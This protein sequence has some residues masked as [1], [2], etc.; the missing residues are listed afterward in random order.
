MTLMHPNP[1][2]H[3][4]SVGLQ[5]TGLVGSVVGF[6][7]VPLFLGFLV[8]WLIAGALAVVLD[9]YAIRTE[10]DTKAMLAALGKLAVLVAALFML[11]SPGSIPAMVPNSIPPDTGPVVM[12]LSILPSEL[13]AMLRRA[14]APM[15]GAAAGM[16]REPGIPPELRA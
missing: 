3:R 1:I 4:I 2:R 16:S 13:G 9:V 7:F 14:P 5:W 8:Q 12:L 15:A 10:S 6:V 11:T